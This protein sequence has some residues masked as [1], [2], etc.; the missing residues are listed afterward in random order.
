NTTMAA[1]PSMQNTNDNTGTT[2]TGTTT[3]RRRRRGR[4]RAAAATS[5]ET[6]GTMTTGTMQTGATSTL[7]RVGET[8]SLD[9]TY[10]GTV[11]G[12]DFGLTGDGTLTDR[13]STRLNSS[14]SQ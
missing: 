4:R 8:A 7:G 13:K 10:T 2:M 9:G 14:H 11:N 6:M 3:G 12:P 5:T 1:E